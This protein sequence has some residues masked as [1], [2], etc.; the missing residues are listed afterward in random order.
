M[1]VEQDSARVGFPPPLIY[2]GVLLLG[3]ACTGLTGKLGPAGPIS[4]VAGIPLLLLG[5]AMILAGG[6]RFRRAHTPAPPWRPVTSLVTTGIY[7]VTRNPMYLGM[8][9]IYAGLAMLMN[10]FT[11]L[12]LL[13]VVLLIIQTQVIA[14]EERYLFGKFGAEYAA[15]K[16]Q[17]GRWF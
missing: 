5:A 16:T 7:R 8:A 14:R 6:V 10:S 1:R 9:L 2:L 11:A 12:L 4:F 3:F 15:Y 13:P 17:V